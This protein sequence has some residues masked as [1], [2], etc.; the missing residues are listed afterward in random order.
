M[1][2]DYKETIVDTTLSRIKLEID[3]EKC[4]PDPNDEYTWCTINVMGKCHY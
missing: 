2:A 1:N 4:N 3:Q